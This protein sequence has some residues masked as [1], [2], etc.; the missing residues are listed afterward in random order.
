MYAVLMRKPF[1]WRLIAI[2]GG[3]FVAFTQSLAGDDHPIGKV[4]HQASEPARAMDPV[5]ESELCE[6][7]LPDFRGDTLSVVFGCH[8]ILKVIHFIL[9][10]QNQTH[11]GRPS[12]NV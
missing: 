6:P 9:L 3:N 8:F 1:G 11:E 2:C 12:K 4:E 5:F 10:W 7:N